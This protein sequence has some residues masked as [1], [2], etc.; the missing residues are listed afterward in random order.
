MDL[1]PSRKGLIST[2]CLGKVTRLAFLWLA[3]DFSATS[4][5]ALANG[6]YLFPAPDVTPVCYVIHENGQRENLTRLC[7]PVTRSQSSSDAAFN[8]AQRND[9]KRQIAINYIAEKLCEGARRG[10]RP[11]GMEEFAL[12]ALHYD[13]TVLGGRRISRQEVQELYSQNRSEIMEIARD[14]CSASN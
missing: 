1:N 3:C 8:E 10:L 14:I 9:Q 2:L 7:R 13:T 12:S 6:R 4:R 11:Q 5:P